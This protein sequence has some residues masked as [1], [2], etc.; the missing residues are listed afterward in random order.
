M[1]KHTL[2]WINQ[3]ETAIIRGLMGLFAD[4]FQG[5]CVWAAGRGS[6]S[7]KI[8]IWLIQM[9]PICGTSGRSRV[10]PQSHLRS[11]QFP[12]QQIFATSDSR[13]LGW[14]ANFHKNHKRPPGCARPHR[15]TR[16]EMNGGA[17]LAACQTRRIAID[18]F[19]YF[20]LSRM[21]TSAKPARIRYYLLTPVHINP[22]AQRERKKKAAEKA[23]TSMNAFNSSLLRSA[24][25][26]WEKSSGI[27]LSPGQSVGVGVG[28]GGVTEEETKKCQMTSAPFPDTNAGSSAS[29]F[30]HRLF[31]KDLK[32][33]ALCLTALEHVS[34][35]RG[36]THTQT[37]KPGNWCS[38]LFR[39]NPPPLARQNVQKWSGWEALAGSVKNIFFLCV[40]VW[41][42]T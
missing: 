12:Q 4:A 22:H 19:A 1:T 39:K 7:N 11:W 42:S 38:F 20:K 21:T 24:R 32:S 33:S 6:H 26:Y 25:Y 34:I 35:L 23:H 31:C 40:M 17:S 15:G 13:Q 29:Q 14:Q 5:L 9:K 10:F 30:K 27:M 36:D 3:K 28:W 8:M 41:F 2:I 18:P 37:H 16:V